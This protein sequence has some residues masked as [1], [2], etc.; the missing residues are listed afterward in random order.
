MENPKDLGKTL[1]LVVALIDRVKNELKA[2]IDALTRMAGPKGDTGATGEKGEQGDRGPKGETGLP[3][4]AGPRGDV[5]AVGPQGIQGERGEK[6]DKGEQGETGPKGDVGEVGPQGEQGIQGVEGLVGPIGPRGDVGPVGETGAQGPSGQRGVKG[7]KGDTGPQGKR[8]EKGEIGARGQKGAK[9]AKGDK[10]DTGAQG[11]KGEK[12]AKGDKGAKG[13]KGDKGDKGEKGDTPEIDL[14]PIKKDLE[15]NFETFTTKLNTDVQKFKGNIIST[16]SGGGS[17]RILDND[18]VEF[19]RVH[20][21][22]GNAILIFDSVKKKFVS[23]SL[24]SILQRLQI[25]LEVQ[26]DKLVDDEGS[27]TY[28]GEATPGSATSAAAWRIKRIEDVNGDLE[29]RFANAT[30]DFDK[31]WDDR[32][33][34]TY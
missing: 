7:E 30:A 22:E 25:D 26:Y 11:P 23:E 21:V 31:I 28:V 16:S 3:G 17:V 29:I 13:A 14:D 20:Q 24:E 32:A 1:G 18:D 12:G 33:T 34:Y 5:G 9:G 2:E 4:I 19:K 10:G 27:F 6:G 15:K 8:G